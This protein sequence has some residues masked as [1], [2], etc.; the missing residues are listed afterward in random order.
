MARVFFK[1]TEAALN[2]ITDQFKL[3]HPLRTSMQYTRNIVEQIAAENPTADDAFFKGRIDPDDNVHGT[4]YR[5][6][7]LDTPWEEQEEQ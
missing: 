6:A 2:N 5:D 1:A 4:G 7:F 3:V